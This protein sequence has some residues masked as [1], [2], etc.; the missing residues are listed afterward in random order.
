[1]IASKEISKICIEILSSKL[2]LIEP[3]LRLNLNYS[4]FSSQFLFKINQ[5]KIFLTKTHILTN[6][7]HCQ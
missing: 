5:K 6:S 1:M 2:G 3:S 7:Q 4:I